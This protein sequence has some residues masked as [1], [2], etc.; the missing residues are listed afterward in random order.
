VQLLPSRPPGDDE[1]CAFEDAEVLH[2]PETRHLELR[3]EL[4]QRAAGTLEE[5]VEQETPRRV[6]EGLEPTIISSGVASGIGLA[7]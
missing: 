3:L 6:C 4:G 1:P 5:P 2:H 7:A